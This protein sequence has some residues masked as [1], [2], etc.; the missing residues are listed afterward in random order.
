MRSENSRV[1]VRRDRPRA[2]L[3]LIPL[4]LLT[5]LAFLR[6]GMPALPARAPEPRTLVRVTREISFEPLRANLVTLGSTDGPEAARVEA[7]RYVSRGAAGYLL[8]EEGRIMII[9][10][11]YDAKAEAVSVAARLRAGENPQSDALSYETPG[12]RLRVRASEEQIRA[13]S[14]GEALLRAQTDALGALAFELDSGEID[15]ETARGRL[16]LASREAAA[17]EAALSEAAGAAP[18]RIAGELIKNLRYLSE[19]E[20]NLAGFKAKSPLFFSG[21]MKYNQIDL[22][23]RHMSFLKGL[24]GT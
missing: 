3:F 19:C 7:A 24:A 22:R 4:V 13:L 17:C 9:G 23:L 14:E 10:A 8:Y 20:E 16:Y 6:F 2:A 5:F 15:S 21:K 12:A 1:R 18:D 11:L